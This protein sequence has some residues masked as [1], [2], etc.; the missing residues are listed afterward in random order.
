M[1]IKGTRYEPIEVLPIGAKPVSQYA[2]ENAKTAV[3]VVYMK[4][5]RHI[6]G[7]KNGTKAPYPG[8]SIRCYC[9]MNYVIPG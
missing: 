3:G 6:D 7:Y 1:R 5:T 2:R 9:G 8:Y 4:Y